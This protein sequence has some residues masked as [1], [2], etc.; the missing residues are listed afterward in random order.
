MEQTSSKL[1]QPGLNLNPKFVPELPFEVM[2]IQI[3]LMSSVYNVGFGYYLIWRN[4]LVFT[5]CKSEIPCHALVIKAKKFNTY[6][7]MTFGS[8]QNLSSKF[9]KSSGR[10]LHAIRFFELGLCEVL[11]RKKN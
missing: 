6:Q 7:L 5:N 1:C 10:F 9:F 3:A 11:S 2:E 4:Q 8:V